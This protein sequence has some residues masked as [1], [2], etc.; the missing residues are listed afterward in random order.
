MHQKIVA[1]QTYFHLVENFVTD[2]DAYKG[3]LHP[4][5]EQVEFPNAVTRNTR[6]NSLA[7]LGAGMA[8]GKKLLRR[9]QFAI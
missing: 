9:Q 2:L 6:H 7:D 8:A 4:A 1:I 3:L 5:L